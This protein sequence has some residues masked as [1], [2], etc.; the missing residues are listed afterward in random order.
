[1]LS[2]VELDVLACPFQGRPWQKDSKICCSNIKHGVLWL[3]KDWD[4]TE[5][6]LGAMS[7][8]LQPAKTYGVLC[9]DP[10]THQSKSKTP[11]SNSK[12]I[13][14][15]YAI[16][17]HPPPPVK[18][19]A[20][21]PPLLSGVGWEGPPSHV[22]LAPPWRPHCST[23]ACTVRVAI[24]VHPRPQSPFGHCPHPRSRVEPIYSLPHH[25]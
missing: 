17:S 22:K 6:R 7:P 20:P 2:I 23:A 1:M 10:C 12:Y 21:P 8:E 24:L 18:A 9:P 3:Q 4:G 19:K 11:S 5:H 15:R 13:M 16:P 14:L 25:T